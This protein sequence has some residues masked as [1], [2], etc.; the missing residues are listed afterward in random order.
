MPS[1]VRAGNIVNITVERNT[2]QELRERE[3]FMQIQDEI[4]QVYSL[5]P[6]CPVISVRSVTQ[7]SITL[8]WDPIVVYNSDFLGIDVMRDKQKLNINLPIAARI[9]KISGLEVGH[10]YELFVVLRTS[11]GKFVSNNVSTETHV[12]ENLTGLYPAFGAFSNDTDV[13]NLVDL[14]ARI[15][16]SYSDDLTAENTHLV[17]TI[18]KV[19]IN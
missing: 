17:C 3:Q 15:D 16:A 11:A 12:L 5:T 18:A 1:G 6:H 8:Q 2:E 13:D 19:K 14:I 4:L 7:T 9:C 10:R